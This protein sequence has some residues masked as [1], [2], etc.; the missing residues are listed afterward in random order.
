[1]EL[2][3][4]KIASFCILIHEYCTFKL[5]IITAAKHGKKVNLTINF[6]K[7]NFVA[8]GFINIRADMTVMFKEIQITCPFIIFSN[9]F[10][11]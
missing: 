8:F 9:E 10:Y 3:F 7:S 4:K 11:V 2:R 5:D 1:M 6:Y